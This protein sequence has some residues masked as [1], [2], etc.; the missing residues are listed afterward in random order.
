[1][2]KAFGKV[3][4][5]EYLLTLCKRL[6]ETREKKKFVIKQQKY[7]IHLAN[8]DYNKLG[9]WIEN[10]TW[11]FPQ[12]RKRGKRKGKERGKRPTEGRDVCMT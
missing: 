5:W 9:R 6:M 10:L 3:F 11:K 12:T 2:R 8:D 7:S 1:M 4:F